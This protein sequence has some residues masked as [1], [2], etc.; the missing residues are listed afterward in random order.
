MQAGTKDPI[1]AMVAAPPRGSVAKRARRLVSA[2]RE[3]GGA[4]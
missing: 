1:E 4:S 3:N 2:R